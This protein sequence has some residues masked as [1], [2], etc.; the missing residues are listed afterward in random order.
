MTTK[1]HELLSW[2]A[3][4]LER[5]SRMSTLLEQKESETVALQSRLSQL[6]QQSQHDNDVVDR[7]V[8][9]EMA[10]RDNE[11]RSAIVKCEAEMV[12]T[13][14]RREQGIMD[15][16]KRREEDIVKSWQVR[17]EE[18]KNEML[19]TIRRRDMWMKNLVE[20]LRSKT[21]TLDRMRKDLEAKLQMMS[22]SSGVK[23]RMFLIVHLYLHVGLFALFT[24]RRQ[25]SPLEEVHNILAPLNRM[26][27][28]DVDEVPVSDE[29]LSNGEPPV[30]HD[31]SQVPCDPI[32]SAIQNILMSAAKE[33]SSVPSTPDLFK[34][35]STPPSLL[36]MNVMD[37]VLA[38]RS[39]SDGG[40]SSRS[41]PPPE[42]P[43]PMSSIFS[44]S[45]TF[46]APD[47]P[48]PF[49]SSLPTGSNIRPDN[50]RSR[51]HFDRLSAPGFSPSDT[52]PMTWYDVAGHPLRISGDEMEPFKV[53]RSKAMSDGM[54]LE[55]VSS[56]VANI[57]L[58]GTC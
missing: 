48:S 17:E 29:P 10:K 14:A 57:Q 2:E 33:P 40:R 30:S 20:E 26:A 7:R 19:E 35:C 45:R 37:E 34:F 18:I 46:G 22:E 11:L 15:A 50:G 27:Y 32:T 31:V 8:R 56:K 43:P 1:E 28:A 3:T 47:S 16:V 41:T 44:V 23:T 9:Q 13:M 25:K 6:E 42:T 21:E 52:N 4:L 55:M 5:E 24:D 51:D 49:P 38:R 54:L 58:G 39:R 36:R 12:A 53:R